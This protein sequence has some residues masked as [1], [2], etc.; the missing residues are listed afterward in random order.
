MGWDGTGRLAGW[1]PLSCPDLTSLPLSPQQTTALTQ[2]LE[3]VP[4]QT[5]YLVVC[6]G[7]VLAVGGVG[8]GAVGRGG[9]QRRKPA[10]TL[11]L[12]RSRPATWR[13][14]SARPRW[15]RSWWAPP[16]PSASRAARRCLSGASQVSRTGAPPPHGAGQGVRAARA[17]AR[18]GPRAQEVAAQSLPALPWP[19]T[20]GWPCWRPW[21]GACTCDTTNPPLP[22]S[23]AIK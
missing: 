20:P 5:G 12:S 18:R 7:A 1:A 17:R 22:Q 21:R 9:E 8:W 19:P 2:G 6:D 10:L 11:L 13:T 15:S 23:H 4:D 16:A 14:T 3:R